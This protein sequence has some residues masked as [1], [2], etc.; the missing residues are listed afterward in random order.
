MNPAQVR[1]ILLP[2]IKKIAEKYDH[3]FIWLDPMMGS[4]YYR[5]IGSD[6]ASFVATSCKLY[7]LEGMSKK[8]W[9]MHLKEKWMYINNFM[10]VDLLVLL[11]PYREK[12]ER[13][14]KEYERT[15]LRDSKNYTA[16]PKRPRR[17]T[18]TQESSRRPRS[19]R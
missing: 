14:Q 7:Y 12:F 4:H 6:A 5:T 18:S 17:R 10:I 2:K 1:K 3:S 11:L 9:I 15:A 13:E 16:I 8:E 19:K